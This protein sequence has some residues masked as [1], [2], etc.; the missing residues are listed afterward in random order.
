MVS[1]SETN[2]TT[3]NQTKQPR[4]SAGLGKRTVRV[5][6]PSPSRPVVRGFLLL[7]LRNKQPSD[8]ETHN[9]DSFPPPYQL[10]TREKEKNGAVGDGHSAKLS[11]GLST[12]W[13]SYPQDD[14]S[15]GKVIHRLV[16]RQ[17]TQLST[18][19]KGYPQDT[20]NAETNRHTYIRNTKK[21]VRKNISEN[22]SE[23]GCYLL[24]KPIEIQS[25]QRNTLATP[26]QGSMKGQP[27][28][29]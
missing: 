17:I 2:A 20:T 18:G 23:T 4:L 15:T 21:I 12:G 13:P 28:W 7:G 16:D 9:T 25:A 29:D 22:I 3:P 6:S 10:E 5:G 11:T 8:I 27:K 24:T 1:R 19:Q 26:T 14:L